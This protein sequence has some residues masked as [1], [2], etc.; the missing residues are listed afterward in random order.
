MNKL[1]FFLLLIFIPGLAEAAVTPDYYIVLG[2][3]TQAAIMNHIITSLNVF[4]GYDATVATTAVRYYKML[5]FVVILGVAGA[6]V[7][8]TLGSLGGGA[9]IAAK[10]YVIYLL[11]VVFILGI[12]YGPTSVVMVQT[13]HNTTYSVHTLP[14]LMAFT[15]SAFTTL[16]K[17]L[18]DMSES[19]FNI[20]NPTDNVFVEGASEG[21]GYA[22]GE[23]ELARAYKTATFGTER[24]LSSQWDAYVR[25]CF[26]LP[27]SAQPGGDKLLTTLFSSTNIRSDLNPTQ[28]GF[29]EELITWNGHTGRCKDFW[30]DNGASTTAFDL[31]YSGLDS[32]IQKFEDN[33]TSTGRYNKLG[34]ALGYL[35][36]LVADNNNIPSAAAIKSAV[37]QAVLSNEYSSTFRSMGIAGQVMAD[38]AEQ[39]NADVQLNGISS[40]L[41]MAEQL[42]MTAFLVFALMMSAFPFVLAFA[43][44]P[45]AL[46]VLMN[47]SQTLLWI[48]LWGPMA[49]ILGI[50][51]DFR[52]DQLAQEYMY[53]V[54]PNGVLSLTPD[55]FID[56]SSEA[57]SIAGLAGYLFIS[58]GAL[59]WML[60]TG[61]GQMLG[62]MMSSFSGAFQNRAN[63]DSQSANSEEMRKT[64]LLSAEMGESISQRE[65]LQYEANMRAG[66]AAGATGGMMHSF[67]RNGSV[68]AITSSHTGAVNGAVGMGESIAKAEKLGNGGMGNTAGRIQGAKA[69]A[70]YGAEASTL[71]SEEKAAK[72]GANNAVNQTMEA[73]SSSDAFQENLD[74]NGEKSMRTTKSVDARTKQVGATNALKATQQETGGGTLDDTANNVVSANSTK[75]A[76]GQSG[77]IKR[78]SK[79]GGATEA[80]HHAATMGE[81][82]GRDNIAT[83]GAI[84]QN[85]GRHGEKNIASAKLLGQMQ[86]HEVKTAAM[87]KHAQQ[88]GQ[89]A[90]AAVED[91]A[92]DSS[93]A[94]AQQTIGKDAEINAQGGSKRAISNT[95]V[96]DAFKGDSQE[97]DAKRN[98]QM[99]REG[100]TNDDAAATVS[101]EKYGKMQT[102]AKHNTDNQDKVDTA[103]GQLEQA[104]ADLKQVEAREA[105]KDEYRESAEKVGASRGELLALEKQKSEME[106]AGASEDDLKAIDGQIEQKTQEVKDNVK[107][108]QGE[109][110]EMSEVAKK[111]PGI[112][113]EQAKANVVAAEQ[114]VKAQEQYKNESQKTGS[115]IG[116]ETIEKAVTGNE[117]T[118]AVGGLDGRHNIGK[119]MGQ[120]EAAGALGEISATGTKADGVIDMME[121]G[122]TEAQVQEMREGLGLREDASNN[123]IAMAYVARG[124]SMQTRTSMDGKNIEATFDNNGNVTFF[125][126]DSTKNFSAGTNVRFN[127]SDTATGYTLQT[128]ADAGD[129]AAVKG[130]SNVLTFATNVGTAKI[131]NA[132]KGGGE[133]VLGGMG[134]D[135]RAIKNALKPKTRG[136]VTKNEGAGKESAI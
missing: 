106:S 105:A 123:E 58:V 129:I 113:L 94:A 67:G 34:G 115:A 49:N 17:E 121:R 46:K 54:D 48:S 38:G 60:V 33:V 89:T 135:V 1:L 25:D 112:S 80:V 122:K 47:Y 65:M 107:A 43:L 136:S 96:N 32:A 100:T 36:A 97:Q 82:K 78:I 2:T 95:A 57:A 35:G 81:D 45:G 86:N 103:K 55:K 10:G 28:T 88:K 85:V 92:D 52:F 134:K 3:E 120:K 69:G 50:F 27:A 7:R 13:K 111:T 124:A 29:G 18:N 70:A 126:S 63:A 74:T 109:I 20:P 131:A 132:A 24:E 66:D 56:V 22:G 26:L 42:P 37:S 93:T 90:P 108:M 62:N 99:N 117:K 4:F 118:D 16:Q 104:K 40:G 75:T 133:N 5:E 73:Q 119:F 59:S 83:S 110:K 116:A 11:S 9:G 77:D 130:F 15:F 79:E 21:L 6:L 61:S 84:E 23:I 64:G 72:V 31:S 8:L 30:N 127:F 51:L 114:N 87:E 76:E 19:A 128:N 14:M 39:A 91:I 125:K 12:A 102:V 68:G 101:E 44:L 98:L 53:G 41:Y 71:G